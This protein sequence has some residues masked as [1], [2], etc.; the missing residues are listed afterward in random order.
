MS[1]TSASSHTLILTH[2]HADF[3]ALASLLAAA[4]LYPQATPVLPRQLNR[5]LEA[6]LAVYRDVLPFVRLE[7]LPRRR[8]EQVVLV[9]AQTVQPVRGMGAQAT[10]LIID[11]HPLMRELLPG[12]SFSGEEV[13]ATTT[14]L[15]EQLA[16]RSISLN[17]TEATLLLLGIYEDTGGLSYETT[18]PRDMRAAAWLMEHGANLLL[19]RRFLHHPL[20]DEQRALYQQLADSSQPYQFSSHAIIIATAVVDE[21]VEEIS[22]LAHK[23]HDLYEPDAIFMLVQM[24]DHIQLVARSISDA[25]DVGKIASALHGGGH[26]RA[27]AALIRDSSLASVLETLVYMLQSQV[28]PTVTVGQI[29]S[30][31]AP[32][33][34]APDETIGDAAERMRR[35]G[36]EGFPVVDGGRV[37]G[38]LTRREIDRAMHHG[39][40]RHPVSR[41]MR[42]GE[43]YVTPEES[44]ETL[45]QV[46][47][48][49]DWGQVPVLDPHT[50]TLL[51][52]VTRTDLLKQWAGAG[53]MR[54]ET[55]DQRMAATL[56]HALLDLIRQAGALAGELS[57]P[58]YAVG[59]FVRD[60]LLGHPNL[61]VDLVVEGDAIRLAQELSRRLGGHVRSHRRFGTA[62]WI[63]PDE[64]RAPVNGALP[65]SLDF[66]TARTE[67]YEHPTA[68]PTVE[69]SS[70]KQDLHRR[71][72]TINTLA[73]RLT[74][75]RWGE[76]LDFYGGRKDLDDGLI[77]VL[78][79]LSF[80]EDPTRILR[81]AR[82]AQRFGF[83]I[84]PRTAELIGNA[85]DLL[86]RVSAE[87]V[88]HELELLLGETEP[89]RAFC[90]LA[91]MGVLSVLHPDLHCNDWFP[92]KA[93]E[94]RRQLQHVRNAVSH[95]PPPMALAPDAAPRLYLALLT[96]D[97]SIESVQAFIG[98]YRLRKSYRDLL[99][100]VARL[101]RQLPRLSQNGLKP[102]EV[103][104]ILDETSDEARLL[105]RVAT[106]SWSVR[107]RLDQYQRRLRHVRSILTGDDL[108]R[109]GLPPGRLY[110]QILTRLR[111]AHLDGDI[112][113]REDEERLVR[114]T[115]AAQRRTAAE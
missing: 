79:S 47:T 23:L 1:P 18:T 107:Q 96:Y 2:E 14:L 40:Q 21:T 74:P 19:V 27:A 24:G 45:R 37:V 89:E 82:F 7:D 106:D 4:R 64:L 44:V 62:K 36:F 113:S 57:F 13:G 50:G 35:Y 65:E 92:A 115:L 15:V 9:D 76:L 29:M 68:L 32:Q 66:A 87:R 105:L 39:L 11:H 46:M 8:V 112:S 72:F 28:Q 86:D 97:M 103:V 42:R 52:I 38:M 94:L 77:R 110:S 93:V 55:L 41:Y 16:E 88:R 98:K 99:S 31:G 43:V 58:L 56:P 73:I 60:L 6:F 100:E 90:R 81:A 51:G 84:E 104:G 59:G 67:F 70:I 53:S 5:N 17:A 78:H 111:A 48:E 63:L 22:T 30:Y 61:D 20:T 12:W 3:D 80:V 54:A 108:R 69:R 101:R 75:D 49:Q 83:Q 33:V 102:S 25:V 91:E 34:L 85:L 114:E 26:S 71:D 109:M 95:A 10:G